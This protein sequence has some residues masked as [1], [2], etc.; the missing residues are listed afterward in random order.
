MEIDSLAIFEAEAVCRPYPGG[1]N[2]PRPELTGATHRLLLHEE[3]LAERIT[4]ALTTGLSFNG[5][6]LRAEEADRD[7][8]RS[9]GEH[10]WWNNCL[11][12]QANDVTIASPQGELTFQ[13]MNYQLLP[14]L[15]RQGQLILLNF[16]VR[17][18]MGYGPSSIPANC[19]GELCHRFNEAVG[20]SVVY[21]APL[22]L[23]GWAELN[24]VVVRAEE[25]GLLL[26][27]K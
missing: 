20:T 8:V 16:T 15:V 18:T 10:P 7:R 23:P 14:S 22:P 6:S 21:S 1:T 11:M 5:V 17:C 24:E 4:T 19:W 12:V 13:W 27:G 25:D 26:L 9:A 2:A 3:E